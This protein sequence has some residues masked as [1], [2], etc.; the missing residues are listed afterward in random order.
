MTFN[1]G[2]NFVSLFRWLL[3]LLFSLLIEKSAEGIT[4]LVN[5]QVIFTEHVVHA[6]LFGL[7]DDLMS[8]TLMPHWTYL[9]GLLQLAI[10][11]L[12]AARYF[13]CLVDPLERI[14]GIH[15][16]QSR[17]ANL[18][19]LEDA[20]KRIGIGHIMLVVGIAIP[21][22]V[23]LFHASTA[24]YDY[25][26][27]ICFLLLLV[28]WDSLL[29][30][31]VLGNLHRLVRI[32]I[33]LQRKRFNVVEWIS[34]L[35]YAAKTFRTIVRK[36]DTGEL[37]AQFAARKAVRD[38]AYD[39]KLKHYTEIEDELKSIK[40]DYGPWNTLDFL[41]LFTGLF[42][43]RLYSLVPPFTNNKLFG[44]IV[45]ILIWFL[46]VSLAWGLTR[47]YISKNQSRSS[48]KFGFV[49]VGVV[50]FLGSLVIYFDS[51]FSIST[52][53]GASEF[54]LVSLICVGTLFFSFLN[55]KA[56]PELWHR[57]LMMLRVK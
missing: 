15:A 34:R 44:L 4:Y 24:F 56:Q 45:P 11:L 30:I 29:F 57:H 52:S 46:L 55:Y 12:F 32:V 20:F 38:A 8:P 36:S 50:L 40:T 33:K 39:T 3:L 2:L 7:P 18:T 43:K 5:K 13:L 41:V 17:Q 9:V 6:P 22:F 28:I 26:Q 37:N 42:D 10:T 25:H 47:A 14:M 35:I 1:L 21:E 51:I 54:L 27:W 49:G 16:E 53:V 48:L 31:V 23:L 19:N